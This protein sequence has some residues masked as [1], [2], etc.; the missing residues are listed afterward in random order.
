MPFFLAVPNAFA[1]SWDIAQGAAE[2]EGSEESAMAKLTMDELWSYC[3]HGA[4]KVCDPSRDDVAPLSA[5]DYDAIISGKCDKTLGTWGA[6]DDGWGADAEREQSE[7]RAQLERE[8]REAASAALARQQ[9]QLGGAS[10]Q[11]PPPPPPSSSSRPR[12]VKTATCWV[13]VVAV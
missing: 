4:E 1:D 7:K 12:W 8:E 3:A 10:Q 2:D 13:A 5:A 9:Q 6:G 11:P